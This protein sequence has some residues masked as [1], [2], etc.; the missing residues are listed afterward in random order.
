[1]MV[2]F[3]GSVQLVADP[4]RHRFRLINILTFIT[5]IV[6]TLERIMLNFLLAECILPLMV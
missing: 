5:V 3:K 1:M 2:T 6:I 4:F